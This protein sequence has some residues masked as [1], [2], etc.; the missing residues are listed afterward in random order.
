MQIQDII[1]Y[2]MYIAHLGA[3]HED[4]GAAFDDACVIS[5]LTNEMKQDIPWSHA[6]GI[7]LYEF[8]DIINLWNG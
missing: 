5:Y 8:V 2:K 4:E 7:H 6:G 3:L 1:E